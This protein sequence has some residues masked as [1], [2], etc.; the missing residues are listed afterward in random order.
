MSFDILLIAQASITFE[1]IT[2]I[3]EVT[4]SLILLLGFVLYL[5]RQESN[6][7]SDA[8]IY[9]C[10]CLDGILIVYNLNRFAD[11]KGIEKWSCSVVSYTFQYTILLGFASASISLALIPFFPKC[12]ENDKPSYYHNLKIN[13]S[14]KN[15]KKVFIGPKFYNSINWIIIIFFIITGIS[16]VSPINLIKHNLSETTETLNI[17]SLNFT[18]LNNASSSNFGAFCEM[19]SNKRNFL[20]SLWF[21]CSFLVFTVVLFNII[22]FIIFPNIVKLNDDMVQKDINNSQTLVNVDQRQQQNLLQQH[23]MSSSDLSIID[24]QS[25]VSPLSIQ[26]RLNCQSNQIGGVSGTSIN[27]KTEPSQFT[28]KNGSSDGRELVERSN[29]FSVL[30]T[31]KKPEVE[32]RSTYKHFKVKKSL[33][34]L[35]SSHINHS[36][37]I[38]P[39]LQTPVKRA[40]STLHYPGVSNSGDSL[41]GGIHNRRGGAQTSDIIMGTSYNRSNV[42]VNPNLQVSTKHGK[43][44]YGSNKSFV[45]SGGESAFPSKNS[46]L[47]SINEDG[48]NKSPCSANSHNSHLASL[49]A[50]FIRT[51]ILYGQLLRQIILGLIL[52]SFNESVNRFFQRSTETKP[53]VDADHGEIA[54]GGTVVALKSNSDNEGNNV[55]EQLKTNIVNSPTSNPLS[56][57][58]SINIKPDNEVLNKEEVEEVLKPINYPVEIQSF[59]ETTDDS[60]V[61]PKRSSINHICGNK[62]LNSSPIRRSSIQFNVGGVVSFSSGSP[63]KSHLNPDFKNGI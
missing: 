7:I 60:V 42:C 19:P 52:T 44:F 25:V 54:T 57:T 51:G 31:S 49:G 58:G 4:A 34:N 17:N 56:E 14:L 3:V 16:V 23:L 36:E 35:Q 8:I 10:S 55:L 12:L 45:L 13:T 21:I 1:I 48:E 37:F 63:L 46:L 53:Y 32:R 59:S 20:L 22:S 41:S 2:I 9:F 40:N 18:N 5:I 43:G 39:V 28:G 6:E 61:F 50:E 29:S 27:L 33:E 26:S 38:S 47:T 30:E 11:I 24:L 62:V 15:L